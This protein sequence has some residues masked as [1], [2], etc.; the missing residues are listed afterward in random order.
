MRQ[1]RP[2]CT[3]IL[4]HT[5]KKC[6]FESI[7]MCINWDDARQKA[8]ERTLNL[9]P[10]K[11]LPLQDFEGGA[12]PFSSEHTESKQWTRLSVFSYR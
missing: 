6:T 10:S 1:Q 11:Y 9:T 5:E 12:T 4:W 2:T 3:P 7:I 8:L